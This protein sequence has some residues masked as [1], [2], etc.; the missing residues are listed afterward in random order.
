MTLL[1]IAA[2][3]FIGAVLR[4]A[5]GNFIKLK[6]KSNFPFST[7]AVNLSGAFLLGIILGMGAEGVLYAFFGIGFLGA[8]TTYSTFMVEAVNLKKTGNGRKAILYLALSYA[9]GLLAAFLGLVCGM[10]VV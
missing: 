7:L 1:A 2:G 8:F 5:I 6:M 9:V 10:A 4:F 3:G